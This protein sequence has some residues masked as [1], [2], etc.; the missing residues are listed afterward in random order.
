MKKG[1]K[2]IHCGA[3]HESLSLLNPEGEVKGEVVSYYFRCEECQ[4]YFK[5]IWVNDE[6]KTVLAA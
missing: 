6:F 5:E 3:D 2:C 4:K 1:E